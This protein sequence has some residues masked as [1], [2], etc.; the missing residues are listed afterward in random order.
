MIPKR[1]ACFIDGFNLY[2]SLDSRRELRKY[3]WLDL[4]KLCQRFLT[5]D[6]R[7]SDVFYFTAYTDWNTGRQSRH[8]AYV[9]INQAQGCKVILGK[10]QEITRVSRV[11]C[12]RPCVK[13][14]SQ[15][16]CDKPY[17]AHEEKMTDVNIAVNIIK[18]CVQK[19]CDA[20]YLLSGDND[21]VPALETAKELCLDIRIRVM[22]P[23]NAK[24]K[25]IMSFCRQNDFKYMRICEQHLAESQFP[26][27]VIVEDK[28]YSKPS[29]W[30]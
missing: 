2:H 19:S 12:R 25:K 21:L 1:A 15:L 5:F 29:H 26:N 11:K 20:V 16:F 6:E 22:L 13:G 4:W 30:S 27:S 3:K 17:P 18:S 24:A 14:S 7:L 28:V 9:A 23:I 8:H 10:F